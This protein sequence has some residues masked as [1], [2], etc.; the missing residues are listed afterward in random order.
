ML[1]SA[2]IIDDLALLG[3]LDDKVAVGTMNRGGLAGASWSIDDRFTAYDT[4]H[5]LAAN[6]DAGKM[7]L[8]IDY[9]DAGTVPTLAARGAR[10]AGTQR[11]DG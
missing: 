1:A 11:R 9:D 6:L 7:L 5:L 2:E 4:A 10:G 8:R 3:V